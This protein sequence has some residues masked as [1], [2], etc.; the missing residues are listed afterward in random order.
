MGTKYL[1]YIRAGKKDTIF[2]ILSANAS[3]VCLAVMLLT[4]RPIHDE[5]VK[6]YSK[7]KHDLFWI[8]DLA[9]DYAD[10]LKK[11]L[12]K[13]CYLKEHRFASFHQMLHAYGYYKVKSYQEANWIFSQ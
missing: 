3:H 10:F 1:L 2:I 5:M 8:K 13:L 4:N 7:I 6:E 11:M 12:L 9:G